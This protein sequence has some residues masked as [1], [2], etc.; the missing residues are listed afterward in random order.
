MRAVLVTWVLLGCALAHADEDADSAGVQEGARFQRRMLN[1]LGFRERPQPSSL[2]RAPDF[3]LE[4]Y[5]RVTS[6]QRTMKTSSGSCTFSDP[7]IRGNIVRSIAENGWTVSPGPE[8]EDVCFRRRLVFNMSS[9]QSQERI[10]GAELRL[11]LPISSHSWLQVH[12]GYSIKIYH[13]AVDTSG[14]IDVTALTSVD[15]FSVH[16]RRS[17]IVRSDVMKVVLPWQTEGKDAVEFLVT[18]T[19]KDYKKGYACPTFDNLHASLIIFSSDR[20]HCR[21][22]RELSNENADPNGMPPSAL[23]EE[24]LEV[25]RRLHLYVDFREVGWQD[26]IIAPPGY[27]AYY[28]AGDCP[29]PLNEKLNG[30]NH[31]IIQTLVNTVAPAAVPRPCCAPTA[32]S[33]ISMLYF[34]ESGNVVLRQYEDMVVEGCGCRRDVSTTALVSVVPT[35]SSLRQREGCPH[36]AV[37]PCSGYAPLSTQPACGNPPP[38]VLAKS[39]SGTSRPA[40]LSLSKSRV[41]CLILRGFCKLCIG[42]VLW[43]CCDFALGE[44]AA[45]QQ[46]CGRRVHDPSLAIRGTMIPGNRSL[47]VLTLCYILLGGRADLIP[48]AGRRNLA[49]QAAAYSPDKID[50]NDDMIRAFES[51]LLNMFGL[52]ERPRPRKN[53]VIPPYMLELYLSQTKDPENP[54]V[55]FNFAGK[56]TST[57]NTVRS[58]HHEEESEAGQPVWEGDDEID[59]RLWFNTSAVPSVELIK[60]AELRL[61]REQIDVDHVQYGDSTDHHLYRV[62][63]YEVMRPNSRTNTDTITRLLDTKLVDV[64]N[65]SWESFDVR[66]AVTKWKNS[67]ERNYGLEVEVVSPKRG[68]LSNHHVRLRRS[69]DMDDHSWQHHR[70]L[71]LTYTD[72]GKGSS[73]S[74]RVASR[75]KRANGRKKQRRRLKANCRRHSLYVDFSDVGWNDWIVAPPGYQAYY[76]HGECPFPLAD[77]LNSTNHAIV[78]TLVN[79]VNPLAVPKACCV[80]TDLS[81][82]SMLYLNEN[83][84][85]VLKNYQ[86]MVVEGCGCR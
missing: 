28:C 9:I 54:S 27:H 77:H 66:S 58:F 2:Q 48:D 69:T 79:S 57:A 33:A 53:L 50:K 15:G 1:I 19:L 44:R 14:R 49:K 23:T 32:L 34:D 17:V 36:G 26:W 81:P 63:V 42:S 86:D 41:G 3:M 70:P 21:S 39:A 38:A 80:P 6:S 8:D 16:H 72:D 84:Q 25:C 12:Q 60:A 20:R 73:N 24:Q 56:S 52:N 45:I 10:K 47:L 85:V 82:I 40:E 31:A 37:G 43:A 35:W 30:T 5:R 67:P 29:F 64:R 75:Q 4:L 65:S 71:L 59:R 22:K 51:S 18:I 62:N 76:C 55:N 61:F 7:H 74:N 83:D 11:S 46:E 78:Q 13:V 68:A